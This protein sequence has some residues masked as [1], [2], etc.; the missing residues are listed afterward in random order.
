M[1]DLEKLADF[2][3]EQKATLEAWLPVDHIPVARAMIRY[4]GSFV[5]ALGHALLCADHENVATIR[6]AFP[7]YWQK[8]TEF[9]KHRKASL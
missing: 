8:Y 9:A 7:D 5:A 6:G 1:N 4:G 3:G 2:L